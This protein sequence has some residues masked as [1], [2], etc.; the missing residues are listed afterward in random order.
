M[1]SSLCRLIRCVFICSGGRAIAKITFGDGEAQ[2]YAY[3]NKD[4]AT[5][6]NDVSGSTNLLS[7]SYTYDKANNILGINSETMVYDNMSR[8]TSSMVGGG[9]TTYTY[10]GASNILGTTNGGT[11]TVYKQCGYYPD[12]LSGTVTQ[13]STD[14]DGNILSITGGWTY[15]YN[16]EDK[17]TAA[18]LSGVT[19]QTDVYE[20]GWEGYAVDEGSG[21][22]G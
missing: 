22:R 1:Q 15:S 9:N 7:L 10:D 16:Y 3:N 8:V 20:A 14:K 5:S 21:E 19:K 17:M 13:C 2:T 18:K 12:S 6:I 11:T 4:Q